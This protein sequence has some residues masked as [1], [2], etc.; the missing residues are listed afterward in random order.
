MIHMIQLFHPLF[1]ALELDHPDQPGSGFAQLWS[2]L[3][4]FAWIM[5]VI[6]GS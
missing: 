6:Q 1:L 2:R 4:G 3:A 5:G